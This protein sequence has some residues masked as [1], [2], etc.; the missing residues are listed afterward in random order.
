MTA[1]GTWRRLLRPTVG[2]AVALGCGI[3]LTACGNSGL[4]LAK[5]A[6]TSVDRSI[7]LLDEAARTSDPATAAALRTKSYNDLLAAL[8]VAAEAAYHDAQWQALMTTLSES[9]EV[10]ETTLVPAL[11]AECHVAAE[12]RLRAAGSALDLDPTAGTTLVAVVHLNGGPR[13]AVSPGQRRVA[14]PATLALAGGPPAVTVAGGAELE[15]VELA[16]GNSSS[17]AICSRPTLTTSGSTFV[18]SQSPAAAVGT[19][20]TPSPSRIWMPSR[21]VE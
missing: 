5:Q 1:T 4:T 6:C 16:D 17:P 3:G 14:L 18:S 12:L 15:V 11:R 19:M 13:S 20:C 21:K 8:P 10:Q 7:A 9:N 2:L